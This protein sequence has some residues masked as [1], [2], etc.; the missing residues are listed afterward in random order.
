MRPRGEVGPAE[1]SFSLSA[2]SAH[3]SVRASDL[4]SWKTILFWSRY[5]LNH[6]ENHIFRLQPDGAVKP[7]VHSDF[8]NQ[9]II[10][11]ERHFG[12]FYA[13]PKRFI[14]DLR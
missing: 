6:A 2:R 10:R 3:Q 11:R 14:F 12:S 4:G 1:G 8:A 9:I 5:V 13:F 7:L